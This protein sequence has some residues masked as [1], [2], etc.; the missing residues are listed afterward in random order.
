MAQVETIS[1][2][3]FEAVFVNTESH[4][5]KVEHTQIFRVTRDTDGKGQVREL[6]RLFY[7]HPDAPEDVIIWIWSWEM[8]NV[9]QESIPAF[10]NAEKLMKSL[11]GLVV[12]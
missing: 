5:K 4:P 12:S 3:N 6:C 8:V 10:E 1:K 7:P 9:K 2:H 11:S